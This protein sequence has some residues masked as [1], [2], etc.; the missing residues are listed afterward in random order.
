M[1]SVFSEGTSEA[2]HKPELAVVEI[3][4]LRAKRSWF[5]MSLMAR[6]SDEGGGVA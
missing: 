4:A 1:L 6:R 3:L 5:V 2:S